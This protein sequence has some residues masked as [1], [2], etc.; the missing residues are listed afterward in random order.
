MN[1]GVRWRDP[2]DGGGAVGAL[3]AWRTR[4]K[5]VRLFGKGEEADR[6]S[7]VRRGEG[8]GM[9]SA[10]ERKDADSQLN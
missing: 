2:C 9:R 4:A 3:G 7:A 1:C 10:C 6:L 5:G 8:E